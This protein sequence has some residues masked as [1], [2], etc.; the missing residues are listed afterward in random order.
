MNRLLGHLGLL[1]LGRGSRLVGML[2]WGPTRSAA[3]KAYDLLRLHGR[4]AV[5][6]PPID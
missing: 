4:V 2:D 3:R 5:P 1:R 6:M